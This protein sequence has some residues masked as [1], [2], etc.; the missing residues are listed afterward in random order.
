MS[1]AIPTLPKQLEPGQPCPCQSGATYAA[2][3]RPALSGERP[4]ATAEALMRSR[5]TA[6]CLN[7]STY[8]LETTHS[9]RRDAWDAERLSRDNQRTTWT[10]LRVLESRGDAEALEGYVHFIARFVE[11][12][13]EGELEERSRFQRE[14]GAWVYVDGATEVSAANRKTG[15]NDPCP[16]GSGKKFKRCCAT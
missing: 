14:A 16:C 11:N 6:F 7:H 9:S 13:R 15:R 3:C 1:T 2:C 10:G 5:Y 4:A 12:D 8:L